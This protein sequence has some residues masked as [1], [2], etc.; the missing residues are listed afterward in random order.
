MLIF[1]KIFITA[2]LTPQLYLAA[3][4][5]RHRFSKA[6]L[7]NL[8]DFILL[9]HQAASLGPET[10]RLIYVLRLDTGQDTEGTLVPQRNKLNLIPL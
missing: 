1:N 4:K 2:L 10:Q 8:T 5:Q 3:E 6:K 9:I 7:K